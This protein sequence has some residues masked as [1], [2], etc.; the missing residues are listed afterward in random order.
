[1]SN[2]L[3]APCEPIKTIDFLDQSKITMHPGGGRSTVVETSE[4]YVRERDATI[5]NMYF[6]AILNFIMPGWGHY[7]IGQRRKAKGILIISLLMRLILFIPLVNMF[8][9]PSLVW[10]MSQC[11]GD[12][13]QMVERLKSGESIEQGE[14]VNDIVAFGIATHV[15]PFRVVIKEKRD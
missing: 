11:F 6:L 5:L 14:C 8:A 7:L 15:A 3:M 4:Q 10:H 13:R 2:G 9:M 12:L 1:M